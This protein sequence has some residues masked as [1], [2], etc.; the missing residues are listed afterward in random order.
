MKIALAC[1][2]LH[3]RFIFGTGF[4]LFVLRKAIKKYN[5]EAAGEL[6]S[7]CREIKKLLKDYKQ[8][9]GPFNIL[10]IEDSKNTRIV[11]KI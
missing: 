6:K 5:K 7:I 11:I 9:N 10:E 1:K 4:V 3:L 8:A 2:K